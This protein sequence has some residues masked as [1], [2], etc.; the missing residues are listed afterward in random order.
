MTRQPKF[1]DVF[2]ISAS[3]SAVTGMLSVERCS[4]FPV[5]N[6]VVA[7]PYESVCAI[8]HVNPVSDHAVS[9]G[10][11]VIVRLFGVLVTTSFSVAESAPPVVGM[12]QLERSKRDE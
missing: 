11:T 3:T 12:L 5:A 9:T 8:V 1:A 2:L 6:V 4:S 10:V 7:E